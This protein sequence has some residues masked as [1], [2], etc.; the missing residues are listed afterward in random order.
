MT[1][2]SD[3]D[4]PPAND[5]AP[6]TETCLHGTAIAI[7]GAGALFIGASGSGKSSLACRLLA[8]GAGLV[9][10][11]QVILRKTPDQTLTMHCP[12]PLE[13]LIEMRGIGIMSVEPVPSARLA[14]VV[15]MDQTELHRLPPPRSHEILGIFV[16]V[17]YGR[18][19]PLLDV[20]VQALLNGARA[21]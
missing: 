15:D 14:L 16:D 17:L 6:D 8:L 2:A 18:D 1:G 9:A 10:D 5:A 7:D 20:G 11:D 12:K 3:Q 21:K 19:N 4:S 13:G